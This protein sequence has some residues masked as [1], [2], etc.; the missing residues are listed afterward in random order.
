M[1]LKEQIVEDMKQAMKAHDKDRLGTI[2]LLL[3]AVK[4]KEVDERITLDD[5]QVVGVIGKLVKQRNDSVA[6]YRAA[7]REDL[8][9]KEEAEIAVLKTY[10][11]AQLTREEVAAVVDEAIAATG[12]SGMAAMGR[13][14]GAVRPKLAGRADMAEVSAIIKAKLAA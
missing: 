13:V 3:A 12:A 7:G 2:R 10:L 9:G 1:T 6:Q 4:Q 5:G 8:A 14:M 11:P